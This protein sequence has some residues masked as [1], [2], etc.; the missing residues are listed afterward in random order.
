MS[1]VLNPEL[2]RRQISYCCIAV[3]LYVYL[4]TNMKYVGKEL[5]IFNVNKLIIILRWRHILL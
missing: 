3:L 2:R 1:V 5:Q 4:L